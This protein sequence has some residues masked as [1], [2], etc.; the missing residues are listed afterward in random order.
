MESLLAAV[1]A[2]RQIS[3]SLEIH[4][5][6]EH[7]IAYPKLLPWLRLG[8]PLRLWY[9]N[10]NLLC[11]WQRLPRNA[12][13]H[14]H[15]VLIMVSGHYRTILYRPDFDH[16]CR[17]VDQLLHIVNTEALVWHTFKFVQ[18]F[19]NKRFDG[20]IKTEHNIGRFQWACDSEEQSVIEKRSTALA[21]II[22]QTCSRH[23]ASPAWGSHTVRL[24]AGQ[25]IDSTSGLVHYIL[26]EKV[27]MPW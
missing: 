24:P 8:P 26:M 4:I 13:V 17:E 14:Q 21:I 18:K 27:Y 9:I 19:Q 16:I 5:C 22:E 20:K 3:H 7:E 12:Q 11:A 2:N 6:S 15:S 1:I 25:S 23:V 10:N